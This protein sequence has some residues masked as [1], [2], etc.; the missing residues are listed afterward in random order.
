M[1]EYIQDKR[2]SGGSNQN[3]RQDRF[4]Q[5]SHDLRKDVYLLFLKIS[6]QFRMQHSKILIHISDTPLFFGLRKENGTMITERRKNLD[7]KVLA[8][9]DT[10]RLYAGK[11]ME[12]LGSQDSHIF[13]IHAFSTAEELKACAQKLQVEILLISGNMME[14]S[15]ENLGIG[16]IILLTD[17]EVYEQFPEYET[18]YKYQSAEQIMKEILRIFAEYASPAVGKYRE[19]KEFAVYGI[20]SPLGRCGKSA[21]A[22]SLARTYGEKKKTLLL[23][24]QSYSISKEQRNE[25]EVWDLEDMIYF[26][27]Q[28]KNTFLYKLG[29]IVRRRENFDYILPMKFPEDLRGVTAG[30]WTEF[31]EKLASESEYQIVVIDFGNDTNG[32]YELL[33]QCT[34]VLMPVLSDQASIKKVENFEWILREKNFERLSETIHKIC[35]PEYRDSR[36]VHA[37]MDDWVKRFIECA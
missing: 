12:A 9:C 16:K 3:C 5:G 22:E 17:G 30:E 6:K 32:I 10:E 28:G 35:L 34:G 19:D 7:V 8:I 21:L 14:Q 36:N 31:I 37:F 18:I 25:N 1:V 11:L 27:R 26:L 20:Y 29:S 13:Q 15:I 24:L 2:L 23:D 33:N 4:G